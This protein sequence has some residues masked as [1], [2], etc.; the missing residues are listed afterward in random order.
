M[1]EQDCSRQRFGARRVNISQQTVLLG[2]LVNL[3]KI[4]IA[5]LSCTS[6]IRYDKIV[7]DWF[8]M[9][10]GGDFGQDVLELLHSICGAPSNLRSIM[11]NTTFALAV[12][13][14]NVG[15]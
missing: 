3:E 1:F 14:A 12:I 2:L 7:E 6:E 11:S 10:D 15:D 5:K 8:G 9:W 13:V 4:G